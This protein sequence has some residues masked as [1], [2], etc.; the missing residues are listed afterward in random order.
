MLHIYDES[1]QVADLHRWELPCRTKIGLVAMRCIFCL[2]ER[3]GTKEH[4]FPVAI[5]G[6]LTTDRVCKPCNS[7]LGSRVDA[8]LSNGFAVRVRRAQ[9]GLAGNHGM[10]PVEYEMLLGVANLADHPGRR[11]HTTFNKTTGRLDIKALHHASNVIMPDGTKARQIV[12]DERDISQLPKSIQRERRRHGMPPLSEEQLAAEVR[13]A[14]EGVTTIENLAVHKTLRVSFAYL[15]HAMIKIAYEM[16][17]LW[18]G[19]SYL[20]DPTAAELRA[21]ICNPDLTSTDGLPG[22]VGDADGCDNFNFWSLDKTHHLVYANTVAESYGIAIAVRVF[23]IH[24]A[25]VWVT[26]DTAR[27]L[28][29]HD[30]P[31]KLRFLSI[32]PGS[33]K[34]R[35][36]PLMDEFLRIA[37]AMGEG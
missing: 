22:Y 7:T 19:E 24:A 31:M 35:D 28:A 10:P 25:V 36:T 1:G 5:G 34:T 16:A 33:G 8:A 17:F 32:E 18:L 11:V 3:P 12:L 15:R 2:Q 37:A 9:L 13:K 6:R 26:K 23:D 4:V 20:D 27:Y 29:G 30:A 21:A 14:A